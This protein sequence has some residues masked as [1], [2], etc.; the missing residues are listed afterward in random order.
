MGVEV[1]RI[2][3][4]GSSPVAGLLAEAFA[5]DPLMQWTLGSRN[6]FRAR[7]TM[8]RLAVRTYLRDGVVE[9][10]A[11]AEATALW[12]PPCYLKSTGITAFFDGVWGLA[13]MLRAVGPDLLRAGR[14]YE[15]MLRHR[16]P[17]PHWYLCAIGT[18][19]A[20]RGGG[21]ASSLLRARL[22]ACDAS[23]TLAYLESSNV[24]N[25]PLYE[26]H[27]FQQ[28]EELRVDDSP[29]LWLMARPP[30]RTP[31]P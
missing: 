1:V 21:A 30:G 3:G 2:E 13:A 14:L 29:P 6:S 26:R 17:E 9:T 20:R 7:R 10:T 25:L 28:L 4:G 15:E 18:L 16:P 5:E 12:G 31:L 8:F 27:G 11:G 24:A 23:G 19:P 22:A